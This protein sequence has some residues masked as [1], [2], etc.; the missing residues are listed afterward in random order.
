MKTLLDRL[1]ELINLNRFMAVLAVLSLVVGVISLKPIFFGAVPDCSLELTELAAL[2]G[3]RELLVQGHNEELK[4]ISDLKL[5]VEEAQEELLELQRRN[6]TLGGLEP[7]IAALS[8]TIGSAEFEISQ[9]SNLALERLNRIDEI[10]VKAS[11]LQKGVLDKG[12][13]GAA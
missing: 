3:E 8:S 11:A 9:R 2:E 1:K 6:L 12:C 13:S 10:D 4:Q 7:T 5:S